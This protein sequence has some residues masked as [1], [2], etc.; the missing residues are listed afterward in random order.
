MSAAA[1][2]E[3]VLI[4]LVLQGE[5]M[6]GLALLMTWGPSFLD[7]I[8]VCKVFP[9]VYG[10]IAR[11]PRAPSWKGGL[12]FLDV[13]AASS[14]ETSLSWKQDFVICHSLDLRACLNKSSHA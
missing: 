1:Q 13:R 10:L 11:S 2:H 5:A 3:N 8:R 4:S 14:C 9:G 6:L 12:G 7:N